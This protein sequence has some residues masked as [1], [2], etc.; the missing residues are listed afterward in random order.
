MELAG[1]NPRRQGAKALEIRGARGVFY[2]TLEMLSLLDGGVCCVVKDGKTVLKVD[3]G[4]A[5]MALSV[6]SNNGT[7]L[8]SISCSSEAFNGV[9]HIEIRVQVGVD[10]VLVLSVLLAVLL[11]S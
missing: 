4:S 9:D 3:S 11:L 10:T 2:G 1:H 8:A 7:K 5:N 6:K